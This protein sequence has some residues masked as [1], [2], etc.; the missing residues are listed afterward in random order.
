LDEKIK[1][2]KSTRNMDRGELNKWK[3]PSLDALEHRAKRKE[4]QASE[5][6]KKVG[7]V[8]LGF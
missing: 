7:Q 8:D 1:D 6:Q 3:K 4:R 2:D 5:A